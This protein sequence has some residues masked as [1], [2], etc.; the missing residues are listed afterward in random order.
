MVRFIVS[1]LVPD[2]TGLLRDVTGVIYALGGNIGQI[3]QTVVNGYFH[4]IFTAE[5]QSSNTPDTV[6]GK[7]KNALP[8]AE[9][10]VQDCPELRDPVIPT[11]AKF[12]VMT[13]GEDRP[14]TIH[15]ITTFLS[16]RAI[17]IEDWM[18]EEDAGQVVYIAQ[19]TVPEK[20]DFR[21]LQSEFRAEMSKR[22]LTAIFCHENIFRATTEIGPIRALLNYSAADNY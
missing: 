13:R 21:K 5:M 22:N 10:V 15:G 12:V 1:I 17:N 18:V 3:R 4:L 19:V 7:L 11:G 14:G 20:T 9:V 6:R 8:N 16:D 2:R